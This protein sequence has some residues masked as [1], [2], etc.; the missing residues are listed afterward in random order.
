MKNGTVSSLALSSNSS[1]PTIHT[2]FPFFLND[3]AAC[4]VWLWQNVLFA[5]RHDI[6]VIGRA[7]AILM[8]HCTVRAQLGR[9][10]CASTLRRTCCASTSLL[11]WFSSSHCV[12]RWVL[13]A[14]RLHL[15][16][17]SLCS[18]ADSD[19]WNQGYLLAAAVP[20]FLG[21]SLPRQSYLVSC[22]PWV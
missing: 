9:T 17:S 15:F 13:C 11:S 20:E 14:Q 22:Y 5:H 10:C 8:V 7:G 2:F 1:V 4:H 18:L 6:F 19:C 12:D 21:S 3:P 16:L